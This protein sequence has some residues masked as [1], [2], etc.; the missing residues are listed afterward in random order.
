MLA[1]QRGLGARL[2]SRAAQAGAVSL[3]LNAGEIDVDGLIFTLS[4][5]VRGPDYDAAR[6]EPELQVIADEIVGS[7]LLSVD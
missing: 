3:G 1:D 5:D 6:I 7:F 4:L 2:W